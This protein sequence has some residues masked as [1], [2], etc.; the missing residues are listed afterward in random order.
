ME[1][2]EEISKGN[3]IFAI[4]LRKG[5]D[6]P[7]ANFFTP[8]EFSQ[9][10]GMLIHEKGIIVKRHRHKLIKREIFKTQE[11]LV[12]LEGKMRVDLYTDEGETLK[13][14]ILT[15]GDAILL[16]QGGHKVEITEDAKII[17]V[18]QGPYSGMEEKEYF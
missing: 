16:A 9:Q 3:K 10:L 4:V 7:G 11:V 17:E 12:L 15:A 5:Y 13:S 2:V 18:K 6:K 1:N 14:V 8:D